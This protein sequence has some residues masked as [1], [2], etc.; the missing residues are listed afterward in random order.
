MYKHGPQQ[1]CQ[2]KKREKHFCPKF[3]GQTQF[4]VGN[5]HFFTSFFN[6]QIH[7]LFFMFNSQSYDFSMLSRLISL[8]YLIPISFLIIPNQI[9]PLLGILSREINSLQHK[10]INHFFFSSF[11]GGFKMWVEGGGKE[12]KRNTYGKCN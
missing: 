5:K 9:L 1:S 7:C 2:G 3:Q 10:S 11:Y 4:T 8:E 12:E 6:F